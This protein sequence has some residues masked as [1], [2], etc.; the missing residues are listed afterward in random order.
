MFRDLLVVL[1]NCVRFYFFCVRSAQ[2]RVENT[3]NPRPTAAGGLFRRPDFGATNL[4]SGPRLVA[5]N[6]ALE[7]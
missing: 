2:R 3:R 6:A 7:L 5:G 4:L 1:P